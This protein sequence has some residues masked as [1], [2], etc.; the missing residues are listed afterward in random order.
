MLSFAIFFLAEYATDLLQGGRR[1]FSWRWGP[2][3]GHVGFEGWL[4]QLAVRLFW[5]FA[6]VFFVVSLSSCSASFVPLPL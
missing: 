4:G 5:L 6:K 2:M 1:Y 3:T